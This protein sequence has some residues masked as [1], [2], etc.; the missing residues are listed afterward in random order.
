[1]M[2]IDVEFLM[3]AMIGIISF[4]GY[5]GRRDVGCDFERDICCRGCL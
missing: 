1:M 3:V 5:F 2:I 4:D